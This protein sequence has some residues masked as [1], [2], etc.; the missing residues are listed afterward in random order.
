MV[1]ENYRASLLRLRTPLDRPKLL[2]KTAQVLGLSRSARQRL[3]WMLWYEANGKNALL[4]AR[5]FGTSP[6][7]FHKWRSLFQEANL[8]SLED[9][10]KAP[11]KKRQRTLTGTEEMRIVALRKQFLRYGKEKLALRYRELYGEKM[12]A[13]HVQKT[14]EKY[15]LYYHPQ[16]NARTQ[17]KRR[18]AQ[19]KKRITELKTKARTG[20]LLCL[21]T[22]V[23]Y[24]WGC[25]RYVFTAVDKHAK[26]AFARMYSSKSSRNAA[27]FLRRLQWLLADK[28]ERVGHDNGSEFQGQFREL[29]RDLDIS[30]YHS[31]PHTPK[32]NA[33]NER[34]NRTLE[35]EF[36][37][38]GNFTSDIPVFNR[39]LTE[40]LV[41]YN[42][43]RPHQSLGYLSPINFI[44]KHQDLL[45]M[46]PS[47][48]IH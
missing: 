23:R 9:R 33:V 14:I 25:K 10:S 27:D 20:F 28:I 13:W 24:S 2:R 1:F 8:R 31:R 16:K 41:E 37:Q 18:K 6:K 26:L 45:P 39:R 32:D 17:A 3:D 4:T 38:M 30:Q 44:Y 19:K 11:K 35:E 29:C 46:Y 34:F 21:D 42:F 15:R 40:W 48:T 12:S 7:T 5:H 22:M 36:I 47:S 43:K